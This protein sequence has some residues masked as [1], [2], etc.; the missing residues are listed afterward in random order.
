V[1]AVSD[2]R[3]RTIPNW[4]TVGGFALGI[5]ANIYVYGPW[6]I[7][8][9]LG[10]FGLA[11]LIYL[12][13]YLLRAMGG[14][15]LKLMAALGTVLGATLWFQLFIF[16]SIVGLIVA[17]VV[18]LIRGALSTTIRNVGFIVSSLVRL[19]APHKERPDL[20]VG[21]AKAIKLAHGA[22][23]AIGALVLVYYCQ[24]LA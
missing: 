8:T 4:I 13:L 23:I 19:K 18:L 7:L 11:V 20:D 17:L 1:A 9:A 2:L 24:N 6:G 21:S 22:T 16:T 10:G 12:P 15:D 3:D 5:A 14:G